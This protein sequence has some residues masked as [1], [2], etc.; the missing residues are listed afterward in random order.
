MQAL[1]GGQ[2]GSREQIRKKAGERKRGKSKAKRKRQP[3]SQLALQPPELHAHRFHKVP[4]YP[5]NKLLFCLFSYF[6]MDFYY[7][8]TK[9]ELRLK[10]LKSLV[11]NY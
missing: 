7:L 5:H 1:R 6:E 11:I 8:P 3:E 9:K 2:F 10:Q 4:L